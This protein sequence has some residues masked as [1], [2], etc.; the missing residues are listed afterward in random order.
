MKKNLLFKGLAMLLLIFIAGDVFAQGQRITGKVTGGD[1][2]LGIPSVNVRVKGTSQGTVSDADGNYNIVVGSDAVLVFSFIGYISQEM[3]V[4]NQT[5]INIVL[6]PDAVALGEVVVTAFGVER[7][8]KAIGY[9]MTSVSGEEVSTVK[10]TNVINSLAGKVAG[11]V[12]SP[13][14]FGPGSSTRVLLRGNNS[15]TGNNQPLY[16]ID[17]V[18]M[19][20][21]GFGS[22]NSDNAGE[23]SRSDY[24]NGIGDINP[25]DVASISVLKGPNAAALYGSRASNG[26]ILITTK[27]GSLNSGL[28]VSVSSSFQ[29]QEAMLL[30]ELQNQYGQG[31]NGNALLT[32]GASWGAQLDG[33]SQPYYTGENRP[34]SAQPG[35]IEDFFRTGS[36]IVNTVAI[37]GGNDKSSARF[38]YTNTQ[39]NSILPNSEI[40]R[41]NF[42]LRSFARL[43][44][45]FSIDAKVSYSQTE[46]TNRASLGTEGVVANLYATPRNVALSDLQ[47]FQNASDFSVRSYTSGGTNPYWVLENDRN[48]DVRSRLLGFVKLDYQLT[49]EL[50]IFARVGGDFTDQK[51]ESVN[52]FGHWFYG[53]G[54]F[55]FSDNKESEVNADFLATYRKQLS[56]DISLTVNFGGNQRISKSERY[57]IF[58][59]G[60][61]IPTQATVASA[62]TLI[63]SYSFERVKKVSSLYASAQLSYQDI[64]F[65]DITGRND[66]SSTLPEANRSFFYPSA[67]LSVLMNEVL[68]LDNSVVNLAKARISWAQVG[69]DTDP[70]Q[71]QNTFILNQNGYLGRT[72]LSR[73]STLFDEDLKPEQVSTFEAGIEWQM[74]GNRFYGDFTYYDIT[75]KDLI[76]GVPVPQATGYSFFNTNVGEINNKGIELLIG[77]VPVETEDFSWDASFNIAHNTNELVEFIDDLE[78]FQFTSTNGGTV[79]VQATRGGGYGDIYG[80]T[81]LTNDQGQMVVNAE[82]IPIADSEKQ[83]LGNYQ[84]D[85]IGG[86]SN[87]F[88]Y[89]DF[90]LSVLID[91]RFGG[92]IYSGADAGL[93]GSGVSNRSL[94]YR[95][96]GVVLDAVTN[97]GTPENPV[98]TQNTE[99]ITAQEYF[100]A[101]GGIA[102]TYVYDQT[103]IRLRE[104]ALTYRVPSSMLSNTFLNSASFSVVGRNLFFISKKID[105]FDPESSYST[106]SFAQGVLYYNLPSLRSYGFT[107][108]LSF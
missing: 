74:Y 78:N 76:W 9:A 15:L 21:S 67:S 80:T 107:V 30:P 59:E 33:S 52:Q 97:T 18:P 71:L 93:D 99:S 20:D 90:S 24:G 82:G 98:W 86:F 34:Y 3:A 16:V 103:N 27:K 73:P 77:G 22:S 57:S 64:L 68:E 87:T 42:N 92:E 40:Q 66:W 46:G 31:S 105:N 104:M 100:G 102:S 2:G 26:V 101:L 35:N 85:W 37:D 81:W 13:G 89:K 8:K 106:T 6:Q 41:H 17:G 96:G 70:F 25:D 19:N 7:E 1:D 48:D 32:T 69:N 50:S 47:N 95:E 83:N 14:T 43:T 45:K 58:G 44:D 88:R 75:S 61:K 56:D 94:L 84:P 23:F 51:I 54:R 65:L 4:G 39:A 36:N 29:A 5:T 53:S 55:N 12:V 79:S 60:F 63:P 49:D 38:S 62:T 91:A 10:E 28:G 11:I 108:N 72:T